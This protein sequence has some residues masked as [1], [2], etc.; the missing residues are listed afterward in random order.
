MP[1]AARNTRKRDTPHTYT[2]EISGRE[3]RRA[4]RMGGRLSRTSYAARVRPSRWQDVYRPH[5][6]N[7]PADGAR[8]TQEPAARTLPLRLSH[9]GPQEVK[10]PRN[11]L[12]GHTNN[13]RMTISRI[14]KYL[15]HHSNA[16]SITSHTWRYGVFNLGVKSLSSIPPR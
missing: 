16:S 5:L 15:L 11:M 7:A 2:R 9:Q 12:M 1:L 13:N 3:L 8:K 6:A 4:R 14:T 10:R